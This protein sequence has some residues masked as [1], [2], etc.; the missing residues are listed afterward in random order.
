[1]REVLKGFLAATESSLPLGHRQSR[2]L[3]GLL[4]GGRAEASGE[5]AL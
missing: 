2:R 3:Q 1:M 4:S 5:A